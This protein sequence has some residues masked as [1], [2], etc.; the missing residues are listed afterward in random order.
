MFL[1]IE[2]LDGFFAYDHLT[3]EPLARLGWSVEEIAWS[4]REVDWSEYDAVVIRSTWD[5]QDSPD[6][7]LTVLSE[8][9]SSAARLFNPLDICHWNFNKTYLRELGERGVPIIP[10]RWLDLLNEES[11]RSLFADVSS[12][13]LVAKPLVGANS[14]GIV[15]FAADDEASIVSAT[16]AYGDQPLMIQPFLS[17]IQSTGEYS[18]FYFAGRYSHAILKT[19]KE[20]DFRVQEEHGGQIEAAIPDE[21][22]REIADK[23]IGV[24]GQ[25]LLYA[26]VDVVFLDDASPVVIELELIE[27]S[28]Y[29]PYDDESPARF[30]EALDTMWSEGRSVTV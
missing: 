9:E 11:A 30:A 14:D 23:A 26:R 1:T 2:K 29:F 10:T 28:L 7:F 21:T 19:P 22:V 18:L 25:T 12:D 5:Y 8:I 24:I 13:H 15:V 20:G 16:R 6:A 3:F 17:Q 27:P 4:R